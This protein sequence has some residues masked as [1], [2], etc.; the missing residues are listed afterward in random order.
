VVIPRF[1]ALYQAR[2]AHLTAWENHRHQSSH[3]ASLTVKT[4]TLA[5]VVAYLGLALSAFVYVPFGAD[6]MVFVQRLLDGRFM[7]MATKTHLFDTAAPARGKL[8]AARLQNQM[9]AYTVTNQAIGFGIETVLPFVQRF[10]AGGMHLPK[11]AD[12]DKKRVGFEDQAPRVRAERT[13]LA[14]V[15]R[16]VA[17]PEYS[18]FADYSEMVTQLGYVALWSTIWPLAPGACLRHAPARVR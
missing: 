5:A 11:K 18:T 4:F 15:R 13:F 17:L 14:R 9:F 16:E 8:N 12:K 6:V 10:A 1:L 3:E 7:G 2:A